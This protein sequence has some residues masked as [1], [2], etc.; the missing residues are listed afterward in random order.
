MAECKKCG[1]EVKWVKRDRWYCENLDGS[2]HW[3]LCSKLYADGFRAN[4]EYFQGRRG[5]KM[6]AGYRYRGREQLIEIQAKPIVGK[7]YKPDG[8]KCGLP[9]WDLCKTDCENRL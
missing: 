8:C 2:D 4:G 6:V 7:Q 5:D 3:D 9:P 1:C